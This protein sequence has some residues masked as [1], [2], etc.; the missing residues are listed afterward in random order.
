[1]SK[2]IDKRTAILSSALELIV[3]HGFHNTPMSLI[4]KH[5]GVS[6]GI[7][8]HYF[9]SKDALIQELYRSVKD[10]LT[11]AIIEG[12]PYRLEPREAMHRIW[13]NVYYFYAAHPQETMFLQQFEN[14]PFYNRWEENADEKTLLLLH[15]IQQYIAKGKIANMPLLVLNDLTINVAMALAKQKI[16]GLIEPDQALL[17]QVAEAA[18]RAIEP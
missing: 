12:E 11:T 15:N 5:A 13:F 16:A 6:A 3:E 8:Y 18:W 9:E 10:R 7:I 14:S 4:A 2:L 17:E 1:M